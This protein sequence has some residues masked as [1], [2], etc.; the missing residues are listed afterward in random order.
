MKNNEFEISIHNTGTDFDIVVSSYEP[1]ISKSLEF[2]EFFRN[3]NFCH[4]FTHFHVL[5]RSTLCFQTL[6]VSYEKTLVVMS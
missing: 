3:T 1:D 5:S 4:F 2:K 6:K